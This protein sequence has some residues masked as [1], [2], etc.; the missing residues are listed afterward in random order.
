[1]KKNITNF[2]ITIIIA[3]ILSMFLPWWS[4]MVAAFATGLFFSLKRFYVFL[5]PFLAITIFWIA[6]ATG[7]LCLITFQIGERIVAPHLKYEGGL[8][9][10]RKNTMFVMWLAL[11][12]V[13][14]IAALSPIFYILWQNIYNSWQLWQKDRKSKSCRS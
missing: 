1:M 9:L 12:F 3:I 10:G 2:I 14:P 11:T 7:V 13:S 8:A 4:V 6:L 5:I